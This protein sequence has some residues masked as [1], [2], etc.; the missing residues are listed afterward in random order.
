MSPG[1]VGGAGH[2]R[3]PR[4]AEPLLQ[5]GEGEDELLRGV[6]PVPAVE[7]DDEVA[8]AELGQTVGRLSVLVDT[9]D[10]AG[11]TRTYVGSSYLELY[12]GQYY[13]SSLYFY[14]LAPSLRLSVQLLIVLIS[15]LGLL[16]VFTREFSSFWKTS[17]PYLYLPFIS[18]FE[19][20]IFS[21]SVCAQI[22]KVVD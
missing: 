5:V 19:K 12:P 6:L 3:G 11:R 18:N 7:D 21:S 9:G 13:Y 2:H 8:A 14:T 22:E 4:L 1:R 17:Q 15:V 16:S 20:I 10:V